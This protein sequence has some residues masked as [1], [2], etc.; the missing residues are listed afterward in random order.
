MTNVGQ[1]PGN[2]ALVSRVKNIL[3]TPNTEWDV[4]EAEPA[5]VKGLYTGYIC[6]L[7]AI[8]PI[9][10]L[11]GSQLFGYHAFFLT[12]HPD[13]IPSLVQAIVQ[14]LMS[15]AGAYVLAVIISELAPSFGGEKNRLQA[16]KLVA[17]SWTAAWIFAVFALVPPASALS[18]IGVYS[19]YLLYLG[20]PK[21]MKAPQDKALTYTIV[22]M[23]VAVVV[24]VVIGAVTASVLAASS[25][26]GTGM[27]SAPAGGT[28]SVGGSKVDL[29]QLAAASKQMEA[30]ANQAQASVN[31]APNGATVQAV[32][33]DTLKG[34]L[35]A[36]LPAGYGRSEV[37]STSGGI[38]GL[39][40]SNAEGVYTKGDARITLTVTDVAAA[41]ALAALG[42][43]FGVQS[44]HETATGY[45]KVHMINGRMVT[46]EWDSQ[47]KNGKYGVMVANRFVVEA[48]GSGAEMADLKAAV[49]AVGPD[50]VAGL[51]KS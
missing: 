32:P 43:A 13:L 35:P 34:L 31:G 21:L 33:A 37:S 27:A 17:Y 44:D 47:S 5:T 20:L 45:E 15:L 11:I 50:R 36:A 22:S 38:G 41:G 10:Q 6:L 42:S 14:Y 2:S 16:L 3:F 28:V 40:G 30:A 24:Y 29:G 39:Q 51:A 9:A 12:I 19:L 7:A 26:M 49:D 4:I 18:I 8:G 25:G 23:I 46:E 48:D 1:G